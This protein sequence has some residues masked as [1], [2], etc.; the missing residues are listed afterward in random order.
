M[1]QRR[2]VHAATHVRVHRTW[3]PRKASEIELMRGSL[4]GLS[5]AIIGTPE[6]LINR[7]IDLKVLNLESE[8]P[9]VKTLPR[10]V[11]ALAIS[12]SLSP[13]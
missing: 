1:A 7:S 11:Q 13:L 8:K 5:T 12:L 2:K 10:D 6:V 3:V 9:H 4:Q